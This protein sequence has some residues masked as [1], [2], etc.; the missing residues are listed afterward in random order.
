MDAVPFMGFLKLEY[1]EMK[2][3]IENRESSISL[4]VVLD[5]GGF[6]AI[7]ELGPRLCSYGRM[8]QLI[9]APVI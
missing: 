8:L 2:V 3:E 5:I 9:P 7:P 6:W 4:F 1:L